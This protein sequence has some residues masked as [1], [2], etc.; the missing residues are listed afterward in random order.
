M[1]TLFTI[2]IYSLCIAIPCTLIGAGIVYCRGP[3]RE[4]TTWV[5]YK[6]TSPK[7]KVYIGQTKQKPVEKRWQGGRGY[8]NN[9]EFWAD[10]QKYG[11]DAFKHEVIHKNIRTWKD[12]QKWERYYIKKYNS[13]E[14][15]YNRTQ[16]G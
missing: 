7:G 2:I 16:G 5:I 6:H 13:F 9:P 10:I 12:C 3:R 1:L 15:G 8:K 14:K 4:K 11:W